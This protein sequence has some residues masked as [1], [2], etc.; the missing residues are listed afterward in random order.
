M[1]L[2]GVFLSKDAGVLHIEKE[3]RCSSDTVRVTWR[4]YSCFSFQGCFKQEA[5]KSS[6]EEKRKKTRLM[7]AIHSF[8]L[9]QP[10][11]CTNAGS[12]TWTYCIMYAKGCV[13]I[14]IHSYKALV[15]PTFTDI[16]CRF[17]W[18]TK[19]KCPSRTYV[20]NIVPCVFCFFPYSPETRQNKEGK[21]RPDQCRGS[22]GSFCR[23]LLC[24]YVLHVLYALTS[25]SPLPFTCCLL[26]ESTFTR[27]AN[28][29]FCL[30]LWT[31]Q[32]PPSLRSLFISFACHVSPAL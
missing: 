4:S 32:I 13:S 11:Y 17:L 10:F 28:I 2:P 20:P 7:T 14:E 5:R 19:H 29:K 24:W 31:Q 9:T 30:L 22:R 23:H 18:K 6:N 26:T 12:R 25:R 8:Q 15:Y 1:C 3:P 21:K 16:F 27:K